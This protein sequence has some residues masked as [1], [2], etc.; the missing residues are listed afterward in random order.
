M[1]S[2]KTPDEFFANQTQWS[3]SLL[4]FREILLKTD[5]EETIKWGAPIYTLEG[6]HVI[7][8]CGFKSYVGMWFYQG[9]LL[10]DPTG[11]LVNA[12]EAKTKALRQMRFT[13]EEAIDYDMVRRYISEAIANQKAGREI[14]PD[15]NKP[16][17]IP[18]ELKHALE[19]DTDLALG[20]N[21]LS[22]SCRREYAEY[23]A[24]PVKPETRLKRLKKILPMLREKV[25]L[26]D[27][28]RK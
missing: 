18:D 3:T 21:S 2:A 28:Y 11:V 16:L 6:K 8:V 26:N 12:N 27:K 23:I 5:L 7:G 19:V 9:A 20:F 17:L 10:S 25:G 22:L 14:K 13:S 24:E 4:K 15:K 1:N